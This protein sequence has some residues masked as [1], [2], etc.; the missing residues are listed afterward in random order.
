MVGEARADF[1]DPDDGQSIHLSIRIVR[2]LV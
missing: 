2:L 1:A